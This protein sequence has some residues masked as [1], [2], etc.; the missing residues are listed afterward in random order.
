MQQQI[1]LVRAEFGR[2]V[3]GER[4]E[5]RAVVRA[6]GA[7]GAPDEQHVLNVLGHC[8]RRGRA[9]QYL[10]SKQEGWQNARIINVNVSKTVRERNPEE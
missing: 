10:D 4:C 2:R 9:R 7:V 8:A 6:G 5:G 1:A 3:D